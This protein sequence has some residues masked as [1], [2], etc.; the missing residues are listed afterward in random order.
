MIHF[1]NNF[2]EFIENKDKCCDLNPSFNIKNEKITFIT[3]NNYLISNY[4][5]E[6]FKTYAIK[7][8]IEILEN[9]K[10]FVNMEKSLENLMS[11]IKT[12]CNLDKKHLFMLNNFDIFFD[13][14]TCFVIAKELIDYI[15]SGS[16]YF[17]GIVFLTN[18]S[19]LIEFFLKESPSHL[20]ISQ[21]WCLD[22]YICRKIEKSNIENLLIESI[23]S[24][25][26]TLACKYF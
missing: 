2:K 10:N 4:F 16:T 6:V 5:Y 24:I 9:S 22:E 17:C 19:K 8:N 7:Q 12:S 15:K 20:K 11:L 26:K 13:D 3:S 23:E 1:L 25:D 18:R 14:E 21:A